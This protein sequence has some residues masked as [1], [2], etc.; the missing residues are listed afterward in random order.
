MDN[1]PELL[2]Q[3][4]TEAGLVEKSIVYW[5]KA[6]QRSAARSAMAEAAAQLHK[7]LEQL[8]FLPNDGWRQRQELE[9]RSVLGAVLQA[10][11]GNAATETGNAY[12]R[13][14][15]LWQQLR[16]PAEFLRIPFGLSRYHVFRGELDSALRLDEDLLRLSRHRNDSTGLL[17]GHSSCGRTQMFAGRF[18]KSGRTL[19]RRSRFMTQTPTAHLSINSNSTPGQLTGVSWNCNLLPRVSGAGIGE[20][21]RRD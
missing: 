12:A 19:K 2:A 18:A 11:K 14:L 4:Y 1:Q 21:P 20:E 5:S 10:L 15:Q 16:A 3:H 7:G 13:A 9:F 17:L 8:V 6:G